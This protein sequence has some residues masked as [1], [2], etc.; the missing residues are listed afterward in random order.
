MKRLEARKSDTN[1]NQYGH[2]SKGSGPENGVKEK[3]GKEGE[4]RLKISNF[5]TEEIT[6]H[7]DMPI[8][9]T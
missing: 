5:L 2:A 8:L 7:T 4:K 6:F 3:S 9:R 1:Y